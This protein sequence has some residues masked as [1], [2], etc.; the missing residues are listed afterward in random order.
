[1]RCFLIY[2]N[3]THEKDKYQLSMGNKV[4]EEIIAVIIKT[5]AYRE[6]MLC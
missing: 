3:K 6:S 1:M 4:N 5:L 2:L